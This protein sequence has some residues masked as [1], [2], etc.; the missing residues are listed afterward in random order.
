VNACNW[1][2]TN[3]RGR[4]G[5]TEQLSAIAGERRT[6]TLFYCPTHYRM[7]MDNRAWLLQQLEEG[8]IRCSGNKLSSKL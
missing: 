4:C 2:D 5:E 7:V 3:M 6:R 1:K 8:I